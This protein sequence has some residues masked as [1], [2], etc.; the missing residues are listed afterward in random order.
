MQIAVDGRLTVIAHEPKSGKELRLE[1][2]VEGV[3]DGAET[4]RLTTLVG[5]ARVRG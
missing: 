4:A 1:A 5:L 2:Y 3:V